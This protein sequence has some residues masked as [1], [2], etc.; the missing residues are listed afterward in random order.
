MAELKGMESFTLN[1]WQ[2]AHFA[3]TNETETTP[4]QKADALRGIL[5]Q[6]CVAR[7]LDRY[8]FKL[9]ILD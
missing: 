5:N 4:G 6:I 9:V 1:K 8:V 3:V 7:S 2:R